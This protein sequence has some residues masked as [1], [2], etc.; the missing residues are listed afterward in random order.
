M[1]QVNHTFKNMQ[2]SESLPKTQQAS[3]ILNTSK[4]HSNVKQV[5]LKKDNNYGKKYVQFIVT[6]QSRQK[7]VLRSVAFENTQFKRFLFG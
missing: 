7:L 1:C 4:S 3:R 6:L 5:L 2:K